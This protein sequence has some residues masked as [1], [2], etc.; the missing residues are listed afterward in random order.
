VQGVEAVTQRG[1]R[2]GIKVAVAV[3]GEAD[4]RVTGQG[5]NFLGARAGGD[6]ER[7]GGVPE[8]VNAK[9]VALLAVNVPGGSPPRAQG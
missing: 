5:S 1:V 8:V 2:V 4:R 7:D 9:P 6:P 3:E